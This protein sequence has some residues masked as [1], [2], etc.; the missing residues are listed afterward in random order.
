MHWDED[1]LPKAGSAGS[2]L[3]A[4]PTYAEDEIDPE[5]RIKPGD[6]IKRDIE[7][8]IDGLVR[9]GTGGMSAFS[10]PV[11]NIPPHR[12]PPKHDDGDDPRY[13]VYEL[14]AD[15]LPDEL[16]CRI[17]PYNHTRHVF[18]EPAWEM[19]FEEYQ[20][21]LHATRGLWHPV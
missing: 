6:T 9:P 3:G 20:Q 16:H 11:D 14:E 4:R 17:D 1:G 19:T 21:A 18:I 2:R 5:D 15:D 8:S 10:P 7:V 13:E 12:R